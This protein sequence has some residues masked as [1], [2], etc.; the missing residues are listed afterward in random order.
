MTF[1]FRAAS[2]QQRKARIG[3]IGPSGSG[4]TYTALG[5]ATG[6]GG[7]IALVDTENSSSELY[8]D[9]FAFD[10]L[11][12]DTF[13]PGTYVQ[14]IRAA[15]QAGYDVLIVDSLSHAWIG[16]DGA[17]EQVDRAAK[18]YSGNSYMAWR[19]VTPAHN[20]LVDALI[21]C[22][23][24]LIVT[25]RAKT[26]Y[27]VDK[28]PK[29]GKVIPRKIGLAPVQRDGLEYEFDITA[30][31]DL[32][33]NL[34]VSKTRMSELSGAVIVS[35]GRDLGMRIATWLTT[36]E[37]PQPA[38]TP[39]PET[40]ASKPATNGRTNGASPAPPPPPE[41][42]AP[43]AA[44]DWSAAQQI[45]DELGLSKPQANAVW[46][47]LGVSARAAGASEVARYCEALRREPQERDV[48]RKAF[49]A[50]CNEAGVEDL[51]AKL[52]AR[53]SWEEESRETVASTKDVP[54]AH[55]RALTAMLRD[56]KITASMVE[57]Y[58][59]QPDSVPA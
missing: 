8:A 6:F 1:A 40:P 33:H 16:K 32:D 51:T 19:D 54:A 23:C 3:L 9:R 41:P 49:F 46:R 36:G 14:A 5:I 2:R 22:R 34:I 52:W 47:T 7:R 12:L 38:P 4:K 39:R 21:R 31:M 28:D 45:A 17:L 10:V 20:E 37:D 30:D 26:A 43:P 24:H 35:P 15:E 53:K 55:L 48:A 50:S 59:A 18:R 13:A 27:E 58:V 11:N 56:G 25:M 57:T 44:V 29:T 42:E